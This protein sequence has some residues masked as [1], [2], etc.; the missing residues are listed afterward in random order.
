MSLAG[1]Y[2]WAWEDKCGGA[3]VSF[4]GVYARIAG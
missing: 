1:P 3:G 2:L 4:D